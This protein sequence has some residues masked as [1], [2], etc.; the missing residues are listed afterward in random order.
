[1]KLVKVPCYNCDSREFK[2]YD[3]E[4]GYNLVKCFSCGLLL[5]N[6]RPSEEDISQAKLTGVHEGESEIAT[7]GRY[8]RRRVKR[9][10]GILNDMFPANE[11][12]KKESTWFDIGCGFGE[13][14][15]ALVSYSD[16]RIKVKGSELNE[17][18]VAVAKKRKLDV[19]FYDLN[20]MD[21]KFDRISLLNVFSHLPDP[22]NF[23]ERLKSLL[24]PGG[25]LLLETGHTSHLD[26]KYQQKPYY[27]PDHLSFANQ[28]I[29]ENILTNIGFNILDTKIYRSP[30]YPRVLNPIEVSIE[31]L[32]I[33]LGK[34]G[35]IKHFFPKQPNRDMYIRC[36][37]N[38]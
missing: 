7:T 36:R 33:V 25:E 5:V 24:K 15:E 13:L 20:E 28:E 30:L 16:S 34:H 18:K 22:V 9:Y 2:E 32:K 12:S 17:I 38:S 1:M 23:L 14:M 6:P 8:A 4:N 26:K 21:I 37:L 35:Q 27:L 29:L 19:D 11:L 10:I 31:L 3:S